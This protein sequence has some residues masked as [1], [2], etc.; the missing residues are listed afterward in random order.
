M[1]GEL[2]L[3]VRTAVAAGRLIAEYSAEGGALADYKGG[4]EPVTVADLASDGLIRDALA[5]RRILSEESSSATWDFGGPLWVVDPLGGT[6]DFSRNHRCVSVSIAF[7]VDG[8]VLAGVVHAP[9]LDETF[10]A[11]KGGGAH[12]NGR[13]ITA[14]APEGLGRSVVGTGFPHDRSDV[15]PLVERVRRLLTHCEDIRRSASPA[16]DVCWTACGR[17]DAHTEDLRPWDVAAAGLIAV[18]AGARRGTLPPGEPGTL[19]T[20]GVLP[21]D[22]NG[23]GFVVAAPTIYDDLVALLSG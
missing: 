7:A 8:E 2:D 13:P 1:S 14:G 20:A 6:A 11:V 5:G 15:E 3:A 21:P 19:E 10:T 18:E 23:E 16:L 12:L 22:L 4:F 9:F 17:L